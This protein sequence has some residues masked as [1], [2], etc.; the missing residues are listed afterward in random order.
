M[1]LCFYLCL[2]FKEHCRCFS[3]FHFYDDF[4]FHLPH[5]R[6]YWV[7][8]PL[9]NRMPVVIRAPQRVVQRS[10]CHLWCVP[11]EE[12]LAFRRWHS[13]SSPCWWAKPIDRKPDVSPG[14]ETEQQEILQA[15]SQD[16]LNTPLH[17]THGT[18]YCNLVV[19]SPADISINSTDGK[20][21]KCSPFTESF[22]LGKTRPLHSFSQWKC[23]FS[24]E[25]SS[26]FWKGPNNS[27]LQQQIPIRGAAAFAK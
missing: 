24:G 19:E 2:S 10:W 4:N 25:G 12:M 3:F 23:T 5:Y 27:E 6:D 1:P 21:G 16:K 8:L 14:S 17:R 13:P 7:L 9:W 11:E 22:C 15:V 26:W 18:D 20:D